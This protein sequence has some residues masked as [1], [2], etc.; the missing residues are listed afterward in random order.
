MNS[1]GT[2]AVSALDPF[3]LAVLDLNFITL[4][5]RSVVSSCLPRELQVTLLRVNSRSRS[6]NLRW[7]TGSLDCVGSLREVTPSPS[8]AASN[9]VVHVLRG[10]EIC[11]RLDHC[12]SHGVCYKVFPLRTIPKGVPVN[13][14]GAIEVPEVVAFNI[15]TSIKD[16]SN[17]IPSDLDSIFGRVLLGLRIVHGFGNFLDS[18]CCS[19][20][21]SL[22]REV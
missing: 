20:R 22:A 7:S 4:N 8:V 18:S 5:G 6:R 12:V 15:G 3:V 14:S 10:F 2:G 21:E 13:P 11:V 1:H 9:L 19:N 16:V 17:L